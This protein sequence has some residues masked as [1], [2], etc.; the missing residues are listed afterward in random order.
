MTFSDENRLD[1]LKYR[2]L[3]PSEDLGSWGFEY[4]RHLAL[5]IGIEYHKRSAADLALMLVPFFLEHNAEAEA[6]DLLSEVDI[7]DEITF[8]LDKNTYERAC[9]YMVRY[10][11]PCSWIITSSFC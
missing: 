9:L 6:V 5:E 3:S 7:V 2:L 11:R 10:V 1:T 4:V 8:C